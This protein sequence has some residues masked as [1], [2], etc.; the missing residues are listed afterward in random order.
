MTF[1]PR[2]RFI[3][4]AQS[5]LLLAGM[6]AIG[7]VALN[8]IVG[9]DLALAIVLGSLGGLLL[10]PGMSKQILIRA[11]RARRLTGRDFPE[12]LAILGE[13]ARRAGLPRVPEL[14][15]IPS[16]LPNAFAMGN[17]EDSVVCVSDGLLRLLNRREL[18]GVLAHEIAH[19]ANRD[20]WIMGLADAMSRAV[21]LAS[22]FGQVI[23]LLNLPLILMGAAYVPWEVPLLLIFSP[24]IMALLQLA[25]SRTREYDADLGGARL[26]GDPEGLAS[27]LLKLERSAG[28]FWEEMILPGRRIP[29]PSLLRTHPPTEER[30][31]RLRALEAPRRPPH[32]ETALRV[33][34]AGRV[35]APR[36]GPWGVW[37]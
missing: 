20:L 26:S 31:R 22:W 15:Y 2:H 28:R 3:N 25:L 19:V 8:A 30:V 14:Y 10:A 34:Q 16:A 27:A 18:A 33:P 9:P 12:G 24:T 36:F 23:L 35:E 29:V 17:P 5:V 21:S 4:L 37:R 13:L 7:W 1:K 11:Y 6:G 32:P